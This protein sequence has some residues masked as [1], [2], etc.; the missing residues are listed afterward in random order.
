MVP[1]RQEPP[2]NAARHRSHKLRPRKHLHPCMILP[3]NLRCNACP[4]GTF[5]SESGS[6]EC[7]P[8]PLGACALAGSAGSGAPRGQTDAAPAQAI[9]QAPGRGPALPARPARSLARTASAWRVRRGAGQNRATP[10]AIASLAGPAR[11]SKRRW[12]RGCSAARP[13]S[14]RACSALPTPSKPR[15]ATGRARP[16]RHIS[17]LPLRA[18]GCSRASPQAWPTR[19]PPFRP[20]SWAT[21]PPPRSAGGARQARQVL[22]R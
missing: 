9:A 14:R 20:P 4:A 8:C 2:Q 21:S 7:R 15:E 10:R 12:R 5:S 18:P 11:Q 1:F 19:S 3:Q 22:R 13:C 16:A 6:T 17:R